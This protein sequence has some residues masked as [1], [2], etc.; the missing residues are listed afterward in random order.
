MKILVSAYACEPNKGS[1]GGVGW[2]WVKQ[3]ARFNEVW[4]ITRVN[5]KTVI[6]KAIEKEKLSNL[7]F[8]YYDLPKYLSFW[9]K[10]NRGIHIYYYL[11]QIGIYFLAK[12]ACQKIS[13]NLIHHVTFVN[14]WTPSFLSLLSV[15]FIW[16]PVGGGETA[17]KKLRGILS[18]KG[19]SFE[20]IRDVVRTIAEYDPFVRLTAKNSRVAI[21]TTPDTEIRLRKLNCKNIIVYNQVGL[22][23]CEIDYLSKIPRNKTRP[24]RFLSVGNLLQLKG[25][26]LGLLA[27]SILYKKYQDCEYWLIGDGPERKKLEKLTIEFDIQRNVKF[28]GKL[29]RAEVLDKYSLCDVLIHPSLH[30]SGG[31]VCVEAMAAGCP[32]ICLN[33]GG[34]PIQ[35]SNDSGFIIS[36]VS[37]KQVIDDIAKSMLE[38][39]ENNSLREEMSNAGE[40][41]VREYYNWDKK[42]IFINQIYRE[43]Y[44][45][46]TNI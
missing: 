42:G 37:S 18:L 35:V 36:A 1:E 24:F 26:H 25:F 43:I 6:E 41:R 40:K 44:D 9:K 4:V 10:G 15:P 3:I 23:R 21:A 30:D 16:G 13:F 7:N 2:N 27:F 31:W 34:P 20:F 28:W 14:Y 29:P 11:W 8:L 22:T 45:N 33:V 17:P 12:K 46:K 38:L 32:V 19:R 39:V 5:N